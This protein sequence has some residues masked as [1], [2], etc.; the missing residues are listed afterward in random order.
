MS[1]QK[2]EFLVR[3]ERELEEIPSA[4]RK[5][6][7]SDFEAHFQEAM[8]AGKSEE[9]IL[10]SLGNV[11]TIANEILEQHREHPAQ[12]RQSEENVQ[13]GD[14][15]IHSDNETL[16]A[17]VHAAGQSLRPSSSSFNQEN[18][19]MSFHS[20]IR[21]LRIQTSEVDVAIE[22]YEG[23]RVGYRL[24]S[25]EPEKFDICDHLDGD[26]YT[27]SARLRYNAKRFFSFI[28][29]Q[30]L[31]YSEHKLYVRVPSSYQGQIQITSESGDIDMQH[32]RSSQLDMELSSGDTVIQQGIFQSVR[33]ASKS[34]DIHMEHCSAERMSVVASSGDVDVR[35]SKTQSMA[36]QTS[37]GDV[38]VEQI[39]ADELRAEVMS[40]D[41]SIREGVGLNWALSSSSG[42]MELEHIRSNLEII[43]RSG[44]VEIDELNGSLMLKSSSG[45]VDCT[46]GR[47]IGPSV[48]ES[49]SGDIDVRISSF[50]AN[51]NIEAITS[52]GDL[53]VK[54]PHVRTETERRDHYR[55]SIGYDGPIVRIASAS[56]DI[57]LRETRV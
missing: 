4:E 49:A 24:E 48:I 40:G 2:L 44:E 23:D 51:I 1:L 33:I 55:G 27:I 43:S 57:D 34:G 6:I 26:T 17:A 31:R 3:L 5:E 8:E 13:T 19:D 21:V 14:E 56:G 15:R 36:I 28:N 53:S 45:D 52:S 32:V 16:H 25:N 39:S 22:S 20:L 7:M 11:Q 54:L 9:E 47:D 30:Q 10:N 37:S 41:L 42:D 29:I 35:H 46:F 12:T 18:D 50:V 38:E